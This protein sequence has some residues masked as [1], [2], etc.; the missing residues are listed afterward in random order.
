MNNKR[1]FTPLLMCLCVVGGILIGTHYAYR[2]GDHTISIA[3]SGGNKL[4]QLLQLIDQN[5]VTATALP[6]TRQCSPI[7]SIAPIVNKAYDRINK[8][9]LCPASDGAFCP[10][11]R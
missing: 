9:S 8:R 6:T 7:A 11:R 10:Q 5:Y 4:S 2:F 3:S 1:R